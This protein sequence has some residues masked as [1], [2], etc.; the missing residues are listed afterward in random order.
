MLIDNTKLQLFTKLSL[1]TLRFVVQ[2]IKREF[3]HI[4]LCKK[5]SIGER[6][7]MWARCKK[8]ES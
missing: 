2:L 7:S 5:R 8:L 6:L 3:L 1:H 4:P